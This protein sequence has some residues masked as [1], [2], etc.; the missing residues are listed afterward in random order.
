MGHGRRGI[1][2]SMEQPIVV[3]VVRVDSHIGTV[4]AVAETRRGRNVDCSR[5]GGG[6]EIGQDFGQGSDLFPAG[7]TI[8]VV[9]DRNGCSS[10]WVLEGVEEGE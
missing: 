8:F 3:D 7:A 10:S 1:R 5:S 9:A 2:Q 6:G 4:T